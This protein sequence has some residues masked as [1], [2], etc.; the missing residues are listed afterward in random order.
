MEE[1]HRVEIAKVTQELEME[2]CRA[3]AT[4][5]A[6]TCVR[7][8]GG[9]ARQQAHVVISRHNPARNRFSFCP[10]VPARARADHPDRRV[11]DG[12]IEVPA[13]PLRPL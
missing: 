11:S 4:M 12:A 6:Y 9:T 8:R 7:A 10:L 2:R 13:L 1:T 3:D 5:A